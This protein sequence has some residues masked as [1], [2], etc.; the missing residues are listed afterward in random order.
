MMKRRRSA[1][2]SLIRENDEV[3]RS[4]LKEHFEHGVRRLWT[5][6]YQGPESHTFMNRKEQS[7]SDISFRT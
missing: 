4:F 3:A 6:R 2:R 5:G 1:A 7:L